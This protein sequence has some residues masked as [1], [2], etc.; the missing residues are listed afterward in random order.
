MMVLANQGDRWQDVDL[1]NM[2]YEEL[3]ALGE[4]VGTESKGVSY[5]VWNMKKMIQS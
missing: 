1:D 5:V 3:V 4:A 2:L